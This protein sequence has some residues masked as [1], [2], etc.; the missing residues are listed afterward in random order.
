MGFQWPPRRRLPREAGF[1]FLVFETHLSP[2]CLQ[3]CPPASPTPS[4]QGEMTLEYLG[5]R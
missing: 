3:P 1:S 4:A 5:T 2:Q